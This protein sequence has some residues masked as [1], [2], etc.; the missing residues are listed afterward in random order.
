MENGK[1][2]FSQPPIFKISEFMGNHKVQF[3]TFCEVVLKLW[4]LSVITRSVK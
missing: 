3:V 1:Y 4:S 2:M